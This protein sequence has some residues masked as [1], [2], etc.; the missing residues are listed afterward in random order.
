MDGGDGPGVAVADLGSGPGEQ[1]GVVAPG[2]D[3]VAGE[4]DGAVSQGHLRAGT[5]GVPPV[6]DLDVDRQ[7]GGGGGGGDGDGAAAAGEPG[8]LAGDL[9]AQGGRVDGA[10]PTGLGVG[11]GGL[12]VTGAEGEAGAA[13]QAWAKRRTSSRWWAGRASHQWANM[14]PRPTAASCAGSPTQ[15]SANGWPARGRRVERGP[16]CLPCLTHPA[17]PSCPAG[18]AGGRRSGAWPA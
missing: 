14:P 3:P 2:G 10:E 8:V 11:G 18:G 16:R 7:G 12:G 5:G 6:L 15:T 13:S 9:V 17:P 4:S 1:G